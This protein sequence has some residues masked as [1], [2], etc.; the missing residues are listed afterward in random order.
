MAAPPPAPPPPEPPPRAP[1]AAGAAAAADPAFLAWCAAHGVRAPRVAPALVAD[2]WRGVAATARVAEGDALMEVP[3]ALLLCAPSAA[4]RDPALAAVL[5]R[6][7]LSSHQ[8]L[9][10]HLLREAARGADSFWA[11]YLRQLPLRY[12]TLLTWS[13]RAAAAL[14]APHAV[15][16][17]APRPTWRGPSLPRKWASWRAWAWAAST[18]LSRTMYHPDDPP[19]GCLTPLADLHN[20]APPPPPFA[21]NVAAGARA[22]AA[23]AEREA[24]PGQRAGAPERGGRPADAA[25][26]GRGGGGG[27]GESPGG[28][29]GSSGGG[30]GGGSKTDDDDAGGG[31]AGAAG[32]DGLHGDGHYDAAAGV[33]RIVARR[34]YQPGEQVYLS[35]GD[36]SNLKLLQFYGFVLADNPHDTAELPVELLQRAL[37]AAL[38]AAAQRVQG[39]RQWRRTAGRSPAAAAAAAAAAPLPELDVAAADCCVHAGGQPS[40]QLLSAL[41]RAAATPAELKAGGHLAASGE[42]ISAPSER[43]ALTA[44]AGAGGGAGGGGGGAA[45]VATPV[46]STEQRQAAEQAEHEAECLLLAVRWRAGHKRALARCAE[47]CRAAL[48]ALGSAETR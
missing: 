11:P 32:G 41:R 45:G 48:A 18:V 44:L 22:L 23:A 43:A 24:P 36:H 17:R 16:P 20:H 7:Q 1:A 38:A 33:Y 31:E 13:E 46:Q 35:Y 10:L 6:H 47:H 34:S 37:A 15:A 5:G 14:Q 42:P 26:G 29:S 4:A 30:G 8:V 19:C 21:P 28:S 39:A 40:W 27:G 2:G 3:A 25:C 12:A 9:E